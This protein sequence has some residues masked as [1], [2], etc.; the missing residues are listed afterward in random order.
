M[1]TYKYNQLANTAQW[2]DGSFSTRV[3]TAVIICENMSDSD[4]YTEELKT[5]ESHSCKL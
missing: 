3:I 2:R 5:N 1:Q 4:F